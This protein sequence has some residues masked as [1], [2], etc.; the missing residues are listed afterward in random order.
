VDIA[1]LIETRLAN[2]GK[3]QMRKRRKEMP[4]GPIKKSRPNTGVQT[5]L[6]YNAKTPQWL[7]EFVKWSDTRG[8]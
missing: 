6:L 4:G 1:V 7:V 3:E 2:P 5:S 8:S